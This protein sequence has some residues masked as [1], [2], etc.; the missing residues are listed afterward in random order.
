MT[1]QFIRAPAF[2]TDSNASTL[3]VD[4]S[5]DAMV[6]VNLIRCTTWLHEIAE[7]SVFF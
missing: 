1:L 4:I 3:L 2:E 6:I 5:R 7:K